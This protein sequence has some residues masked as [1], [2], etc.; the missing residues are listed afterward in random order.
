[1]ILALSQFRSPN[2]TTKT[3]LPDHWLCSLSLVIPPPP[4][5][6]HPCREAQDAG[7][8]LAALGVQATPLAAISDGACGVVTPT[9]VAS[10]EAGA[11]TLPT[12]AVVNCKLA[13]ALAYWLRDSVQ[14]AAMVS[15]GARVTSLRVA[16]S[17]ECRTRDHVAGAKLS[18]HAFGNAIDL[19]AFKVNGG[20]IE[21]GGGHEPGEQNFLDTIRAKACGT[22]KTVLGPGSDGYHADHFHLDLAERGKNKNA[23]FCQ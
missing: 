3:S 19:S 10:L 23:L 20:W 2:R 12:R 5:P 6:N 9:A 7:L 1:M 22:F 11:V 21:V 13:E 15:L 8:S 18:E 4:L 14:P 17:Y 16:G